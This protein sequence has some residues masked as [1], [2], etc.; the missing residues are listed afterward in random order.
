M[1]HY[2]EYNHNNSGGVDWVTPEMWE[3]LVKAGWKV[4]R[5]S[6]WGSRIH[7]AERHGLSLHDAI[8]EWQSITGLDPAAMGCNCCGR[9]H[10]FYEYDENDNLVASMNV[11]YGPATWSVDNG[12]N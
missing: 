9:P 12:K 8:V 6:S 10:S 1:S 2:V 7:S 4:T 11:H 5:T 3:N